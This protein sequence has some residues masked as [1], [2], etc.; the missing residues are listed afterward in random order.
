[1]ILAINSVHAHGYIHRYVE[2]EVVLLIISWWLFEQFRFFW[3]STLLCRDLKP[4]NIL[5]DANGHIKLSDF[6]LCTSGSESHLS[7][8]YQTV[9]PKEFDPNY[10]KNKLQ[11]LH[12]SQL[13]TKIEKQRSWDRKRKTL[14][15]STV[16]MKQYFSA[17]AMSHS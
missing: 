5:I 14:S 3:I 4:D 9:V 7:S 1:L 17:F 11:V 13:R 6:G 16:G 10:D 15:Y 12:D 2:D 8:F